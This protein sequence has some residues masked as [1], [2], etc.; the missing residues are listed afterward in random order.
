MPVMVISVRTRALMGLS[1]APTALRR[2]ISAERSITLAV[3]KLEI[4]RAEPARLRAVMRSMRSWVFLR[5]APSDS[6]TCRMGLET[7]SVITSSIW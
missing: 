5:M 3:T 6:A 2:P 7:A 4:P 1:W